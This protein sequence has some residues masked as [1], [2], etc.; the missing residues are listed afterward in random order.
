MPDTPA[1]QASH[2]DIAN[3]VGFALAGRL[4]GAEFNRGGHA[5]ADPFTYAFVGD[6]CLMEGISHEVSSL[7]GTLALGKLIVVYD[8]NGI[9]IDGKVQGW[10]RDD[11][12]KRFEAYGWNVI[13][14]VDGHDSRAVAHAI[15]AAPAA[16]RPTPICPRTL[17][18]KGSPNKPGADQGH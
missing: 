2:A 17:I 7:A 4:L 6:G 10:F 5:M 11:T 15:E 1:T 14:N 3:A 13:A 16:S 18:G 12:P 9:S 8:D